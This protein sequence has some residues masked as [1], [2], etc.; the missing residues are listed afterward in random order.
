MVL[1]HN[2]RHHIAQVTLEFGIFVCDDRC[3]LAFIVTTWF[4][5][6]GQLCTITCRNGLVLEYWLRLVI[7]L[8]NKYL[9]CHG[10]RTVVFAA[11]QALADVFVRLPDQELAWKRYMRG[12]S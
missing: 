6:A 4:K 7:V 12:T 10:G 1:Y 11:Q 2:L 3:L 8:H 5:P 9:Q